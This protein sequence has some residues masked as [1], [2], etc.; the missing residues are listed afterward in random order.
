MKTQFVIK[1][2]P[3][4]R[5]SVK[6]WKCLRPAD[7]NALDFVQETLDDNG[8]VVSTSTYNFLLSDNELKSLKE[9]LPA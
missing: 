1:D 8:N 5:I 3:G 6:T 9:Q 7:L 2:Q 4:F